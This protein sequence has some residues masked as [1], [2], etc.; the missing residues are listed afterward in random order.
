[1]MFHIDEYDGRREADGKY[2]QTYTY[3]Y[4]Y[5]YTHTVCIYIFYRCKV[6][7]LSDIVSGNPLVVKMIVSFNRKGAGQAS[8]RDMLGPLIHKVSI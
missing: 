2:T 3:I 5:Q 6:L 1:M 8:L 7:R 4:A